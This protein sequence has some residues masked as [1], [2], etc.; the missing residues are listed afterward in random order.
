GHTPLGTE[1]AAKATTREDLAAL[2]KKAAVPSNSALVSAGDLTEDQ[3]RGLAEEY[4]GAWNGAH[5]TAPV[6]EAPA[7]PSPAVY[8]S[9]K[10]GS[11]QTMLFA[12]GVGAARTTPDFAPLT[13]MNTIFGGLFSSRLNMNLREQ[14]GY[15]YGARSRFDYRRGVGSF[16]A[17]AP[18]KTGDT[19]AATQ[20]IFSELKKMGGG[21]VTEE[22]LKLAKDNYTQSLVGRFQTTQTLAGTF[23]ALHMFGLP[24]DY[25][26]KLPPTIEAVNAA[27]VRRV[28]Q[29]YIDPS[30]MFVVAVGDRAKIEPELSKLNVG[31]VQVAAQ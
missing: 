30:H 20:E 26:E 29:K 8:A 23:A 16:W 3:A 11:P 4:F 5:F 14:H 6:P 25:F 21:D 18:V 27:D 15:T 19:G 24:A 7:P 13:V 12:V 10:P 22:E 17:A 1:A 2:W 28:A 31:A 9:D